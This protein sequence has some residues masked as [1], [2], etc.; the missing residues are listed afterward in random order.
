MQH[1][2]TKPPSGTVIIS[3]YNHPE[4]LE[5]TLW[6]YEM[7]TCANFDIVIADDGS[8]NATADLIARFRRESALNISRVWQPDNGFRKCE[9]LNKAILESKGDYLIFTDQDCIPRED[10]VELHLRYAEAGYFLSGGYFKLP[11]SIS[12]QISRDDIA[13]R[14]AF[15]VGWLHKQGL[16]R[17]FKE[18]KLWRSKPYAALLNGITPA[19]A[20]WNGCNSSCLKSDALRV[21][22]FNTLL[23]YGGEDREFGERLINAGLKSQQ[24]RYTLVCLHLDHARPYKDDKLIAYNNSVRKKN[25]KE[26]RIQTLTGI[27][28]IQAI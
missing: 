8:D 19:R 10:F 13:S 15:D 14:R 12:R 22:G 6:G 25:R 5:K 16:K 7:Q 4:W 26:K 27:E 28:N 11:M 3:T 24:L 20:S 9:I 17:T 18:T 21:N 23:K 1:T 2:G